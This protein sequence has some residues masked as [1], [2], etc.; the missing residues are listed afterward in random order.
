[1]ND[2]CATTLPHTAQTLA[3]SLRAE[4]Q[5]M[6]DEAIICQGLTTRTRPWLSLPRDMNDE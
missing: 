5:I 1:M 4:Q 2:A 6:L 3:Q